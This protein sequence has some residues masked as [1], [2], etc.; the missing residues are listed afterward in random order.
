MSDRVKLQLAKDLSSL[1]AEIIYAELFL[2]NLLSM[3]EN[4]SN[5][6]KT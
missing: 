5:K 2:F 4:D 6:L 1:I 3:R